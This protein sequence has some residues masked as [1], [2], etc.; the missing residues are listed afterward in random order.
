VDHAA[1]VSQVNDLQQLVNS[2]SQGQVASDDRDLANLREEVSDLKRLVGT[3]GVRVGNW[4]FDNVEQI[5]S[6]L[7]EERV[8]PDIMAI[9]MDGISAFAQHLSGQINE[10]KMSNESKMM[11][12]DGISDAVSFKYMTSFR[13][14]QPP[15]FLSSMR[16]PVKEGDRFPML[17]NREAWE[18]KLGSKGG[19][20]DLERALGEISKTGQNYILQHLPPGRTQNL[21][22]HLLM[23]S[24]AW[25]T[26][27]IAHINLEIQTILQYG[28]DEKRTFELVSKQ[29]VVIMDAIWAVRMM[30]Q[31]FSPD[32]DKHL[33]LAC[34]IMITMK[35]HMVM[36]SFAEPGFATHTLISTIFI[37]FLV[38]VTGGNFASGVEG[39]FQDL[40]GKVKKASEDLTATKRAFTARMDSMTGNIKSLCTKADVKYTPYNTAKGN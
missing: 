3:Q 13:E 10:T 37:R 25:W 15:F 28:I 17:L 4:T 19:R 6:M 30:M 20:R 21:C 16:I 24:V 8:D 2:M 26:K 7:T 29:L 33:F 39:Q 34:M 38:E 36:E 31:E 9:A 11:R 35:A 14:K 12:A 32:R 5:V 1:L 40:E 22:I 23:T 27:L 18:G